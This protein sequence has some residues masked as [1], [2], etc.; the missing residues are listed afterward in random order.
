MVNLQVPLDQ[1]PLD[2][3]TFVWVIHV[4]VIHVKCVTRTCVNWTCVNWT[5]VTRTCV[6]QTNRHGHVSPGPMLGHHQL[7]TNEAKVDIAR[8]KF[9][10]VWPKFVYTYL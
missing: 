4:W 3:V 9:D 10:N 6:T 1:V 2:Q 5:C 7:E 8:I